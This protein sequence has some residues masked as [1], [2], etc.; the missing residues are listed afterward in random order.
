[1][2]CL[3][4]SADFH[5]SGL[6]LLRFSAGRAQRYT[7]RFSTCSQQPSSSQSH[8]SNLISR[9]AGKHRPNGPNSVFDVH[10]AQCLTFLLFLQLFWSNRVVFGGHTW[11]LPEGN[12]SAAME[13]NTDSRH[14]VKPEKL[15]QTIKIITCTFINY[16]IRS[17][18]DSG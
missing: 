2:S 10:T 7:N 11:F 5:T 15:N 18:L 8:N 9:S 1:M 3:V 4:R 14:T 12:L 6:Q 13:T 16:T 17:V